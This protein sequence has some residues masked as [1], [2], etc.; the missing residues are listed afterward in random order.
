MDRYE[1]LKTINITHGLTNSPE[2]RSWRAMI[3]RCTNP[4]ID[5]YKYY[6]AKGI[7][8]DPSW[9]GELGF[10][11]FL[12]HVGKRPSLNHTLDRKYIKGDYKPGNV[13]WSTKREQCFNK[14]NNLK[15]E[16]KGKLQSLEE[17][18]YKLDLRYDNLYS[19]YKR[20]Y[21]IEDAIYL[22]ISRG[23]VT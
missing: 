13:K 23:Y 10:Q 12:S 14:S 22:C 5:S 21:N 9:L 7:K 17:L 8:I 2:Y 18:A 16:Y 6:G 15:V 11:N 19:Y 4:K 20:K 1:H 3:N